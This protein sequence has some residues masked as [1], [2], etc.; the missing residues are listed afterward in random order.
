MVTGGEFHRNAM[1]RNFASLKPKKET[2]EASRHVPLTTGA[3]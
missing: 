1:N 3:A 2:M